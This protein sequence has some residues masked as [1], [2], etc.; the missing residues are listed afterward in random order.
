MDERYVRRRGRLLR[1][2][3]DAAVDALLV[4]GVTNVSW[5]TGF[6]GDSSWLLLGTGVCV[7]VSDGRYAIQIEEECP[8]LDMLIRKP[9]VKLHEAAAKAVKAAGVRK[10]AF[11]SHVLTF[12]SVEQLAAAAPQC[13]LLPVSGIVEELRASKDARELAEIRSAVRMAVRG[14]N[15]LRASLTR[16]MTE[17]EI[18]HEL[19]QAMR[20]FGADGE[21][22]ETIVAAD[23]RAALAH[24][25]PRRRPIRDCD[26]LLIDWGA[27]APSGYKSDLT[28]MLVF[29]KPSKKLEQ[30]YRTVLEAQTR[31]IHAA[32]PGISCEA[33][34]RVARDYLKSQGYARYFGH[35]LGHG[36]G[37]DIHEMPRL[38]PNSKTLLAAGMVV[39]VEPGVYLPGW[40]GVRI[41]DDVLITRDGHDVLSHAL[42]KSFEASLV[43]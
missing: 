31:A 4:S 42:G 25:R 33:V 11:E 36:I 14:Y 18:A 43:D 32:R 39:T 16:D 29:G 3:R 40:G 12:E 35:G 30:V 15:A 26:W 5:L 24:Y 7:L 2:A 34:D 21:S 9:H 6:S 23:D 1:R 38:A 13:T 10:L 41:E 19:E 28:R 27:E 22:F 37:L 17:L 8:G 20:R